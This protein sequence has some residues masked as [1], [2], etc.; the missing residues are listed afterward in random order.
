MYVRKGFILLVSTVSSKIP[1]LHSA[2]FLF[3]YTAR[4]IKFPQYFRNEAYLTRSAAKSGQIC[5]LW[6]FKF[7]LR[8]FFSTHPLS[9][10]D[11]TKINRPGRMYW[12]NF[13]QPTAHVQ[14]NIFVKNFIEAYS[15][16]LYASFATF[17][18]QI[19]QLF[20][21]QW[22]SLKYVWP[23]WTQKVPKEV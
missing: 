3:G 22:E 8:P 13:W 10:T 12:T 11:S 14:Q 15:L 1:R 17:C 21:A 19:G 9:V 18:A 6:N 2:I 4:R 16:H 7:Y 5:F 20:E 23:I